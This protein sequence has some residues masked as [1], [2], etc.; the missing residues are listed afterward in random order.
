MFPLS[1]LSNCTPA[2]PAVSSNS[3]ASEFLLCARPPVIIALLAELLVSDG[4]VGS[5]ER[6]Q[7]IGIAHDVDGKNLVV[8]NY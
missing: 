7:L 3:P 4:G 5:V 6:P 8:V 2:P 1:S